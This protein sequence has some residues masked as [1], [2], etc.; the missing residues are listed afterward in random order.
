MKKYLLKI[1]KN[2]EFERG[3]GYEEFETINESNITGISID[4]NYHENRYGFELSQSEIDTAMLHIYA[5]KKFLDSGEDI[6]LVL[7][8]NVNV[9]GLDFS[10]IALEDFPDGFDILFP[11]DKQ[12][13]T[14]SK[15]TLNPNIRE[16]V[17]YEPYFLGFEWGISIYFLSREGCSKLLKAV[18]S[19][20]QRIDDEILQLATLGTI[21][22][23]SIPYDWLGAE[24]IL[25][26]THIDRIINIRRS[27]FSFNSWSNKSKSLLQDLL[28]HISDV[29]KSIGAHLLLQGGSHLGFVRHG[30]VMGWDDDVDIGIEEDML[31]SFVQNIEDEK[32]KVTRRIE[33]WSQ[34]EFYK[35]WSID[36]EEIPS[37]TYRFPAVDIWLYNRTQKDII[38]KNGIV[39]PN[40]A[41]HPMKQVLFEKSTF[42]IVGNSIEV[43]DSRYKDWKSKIRIYALS[44]AQEV[45]SNPTLSTDIEVDGEGRIIQRD[46]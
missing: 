12:P 22:L 24:N 45:P 13:L 3:C 30:G 10:D 4:S 19:V 26:K 23:F 37:Y 32:I 11:F 27:I 17:E 35:V 40:S 20:K 6:C 44:H 31:P 39:C 29:G 1:P 18:D 16:Q 33:P 7:E 42:Y 15:V 14:V 5:W 21:Q 38:F 25:K 9:E 43:L 46:L 8:E 2:I 34:I 28:R 41:I 36:G